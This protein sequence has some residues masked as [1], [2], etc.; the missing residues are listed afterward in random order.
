MTHEPVQIAAAGSTLVGD[1]WRGDGA[2]IVLLHAGVCDRRC[3]RDVGAAARWRRTRR[4][5]V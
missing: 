2:T 1:R 4:R 3:W 5:R